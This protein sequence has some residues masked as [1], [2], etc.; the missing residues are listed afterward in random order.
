MEYKTRARGPSLRVIR[1]EKGVKCHGDDM[2]FRQ[3]IFFIIIEVFE[4]W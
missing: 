1:L 2:V 4:F 3:L